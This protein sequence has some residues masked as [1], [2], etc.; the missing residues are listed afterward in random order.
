MSLIVSA[1]DPPS[2]TFFGDSSSRDR[3]YMVAG[4]FAVRGTR[5]AEVRTRIDRIRNDVGMASEFHWS[6]YRGGDRKEAYEALVRYAFELVKSRQAALHIIIAKFKGYAHKA[7]PGDTKDT[8]INR[9]YYQLLLH[10]VARFYGPHCA[11]RVRLDSGADC[12]DICALRGAV[13]ADAYK[14]YRTRPNCIRAIEP[15]C[16]S[17]ANIVQMADVVLGAVAARRNNIS[18]AKPA[19]AELA[20]YVQ[21]QAGHSDWAISTP[22]SARFLTVWN[23][24]TKGDGSPRL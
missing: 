20:A 23:H 18:Y 21:E 11:I 3:T 6:E 17:R 19:K 24:E 4:G 2:L 10:R 8:S 15:V 16:S 5:I 1:F 13:C 12:K 7:K 14:T 9:M 22:P